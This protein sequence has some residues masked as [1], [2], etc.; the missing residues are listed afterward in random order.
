M[1]EL[2]LAREPR[3]VSPLGHQLL[4]VIYVQKG[5]R[6]TLLFMPGTF[7][8]RTAGD[9]RRYAAEWITAIRETVKAA[10]GNDLS[11]RTDRVTV[12]LASPWGTLLV[13]V[14]L[15]A[16]AVILLSISLHRGGSAQ[17]SPVAVPVQR[18]W[19]AYTVP[20]QV[21]AEVR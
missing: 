18:A 5:E 7:W 4:S 21:P 1:Q 8:F 14:P 2:G 10:T 6:K 12:V 17:S 15:L 19:K 13:F 11:C 3:W 16:I 9:T 20:R